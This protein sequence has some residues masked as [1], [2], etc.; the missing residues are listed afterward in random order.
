M[1]QYGLLFV[2]EDRTFLIEEFS[3]LDELKKEFQSRVRVSEKYKIIPVKFL[4]VKIN[5]EDDGMD[6][7]VIGGVER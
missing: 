6:D 5:I 2:N 4:Q 7:A 1:K 3:S